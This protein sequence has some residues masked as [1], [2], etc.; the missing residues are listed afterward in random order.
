M[1]R[2]TVNYGDII[3]SSSAHEHV[4]KSQNGNGGLSKEDA[5]LIAEHLSKAPDKDWWQ[6][7]FAVALDEVGDV[8]EA[9]AMADAAA[10]QG[11][12]LPAMKPSPFGKRS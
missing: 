10:Q 3:H 1:S 11:Q 5:A 12:G 8:A 6:A 9:V 4:N 7:L 2:I